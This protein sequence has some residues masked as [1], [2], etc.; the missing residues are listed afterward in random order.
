MNFKPKTWILL[1]LMLFIAAWFFW[2]QGEQRRSAQPPKAGTNTSLVTTRT[3]VAKAK[4][5]TQA[6]QPAVVFPNSLIVSQTASNIVHP[7]NA[8]DYKVSNTPETLDKLVVKDS[9][10]L[11]RN[12]WIDTAAA[13][14]LPIPAE[15]RATEDPGSYIVQSAG[16]ITPAFRQQLGEAGAAIISY[17][18]NNAYLVRLTASGARDLANSPLVQAVL[19]NE[20]LYKLEM[21]L[22]PEALGQRANPAGKVL[23]VTIFDDLRDAATAGIKNLGGVVVGHD[24]TPFG[25]QLL[26]QVPLGNENTVQKL[27]RMESVQGIELYR[28]RVVMNDLTRE[29]VKVSANTVTNVNY[30]G[31]TG[32]NVIVNVNDTGAYAGHPDLSNRVFGVIVTNALGQQLVNTYED[33][34]GHGTH[35]SGIIMSSGEN[36][37]SGNFLTNFNSVSNANFRGMAP[38]ASVF[39][40]PFNRDLSD[41]LNSYSSDAGLAEWA[42]RTNLL[43]FGR[44]NTL[45]SNNS[46][47]YGSQSY[48]SSAAIFDGAARDSLPDVPGSQPVLFIFAAGNSGSAGDLCSIT[49]FADTINSPATMK[50]GIA[51][52]A[53]ENLRNIGSNAVLTLGKSNLYYTCDNCNLFTNNDAFLGRTDS[54]NQVASFSSRGNTGISTTSIG[55]FKPDVVAPGTFIIS[56]R[57]PST[58]WNSSAYYNPTNAIDGY[59]FPQLLMK[60]GQTNSFPPVIV[61]DNTVRIA[62][63]ATPAVTSS[64]NVVI[65]ASTNAL[66]SSD[67]ASFV[68]TNSLIITNF[69]SSNCFGDLWFVDVVIPGTEQVVFDFSARVLATNKGSILTVLSNMNESLDPNELYRFESGTSMAAPAVSGLAALMQEFFEQRLG[70]TNSPALMKALLINGARSVSSDYHLQIDPLVNQQGWGLVNIQ[71]SIPALLNTLSNTTDEAAWPIRFYDQ[72]PTNALSTGQSHT[73]A[74]SVTNALAVRAPLRVTLVWTDPPGNPAATINLV[75]DLDLIV[76]NNDT[77]EVFFGNNFTGGRDFSD[78]N[79]L[80]SNSVPVYSSGI[81]NDV[82]NN[83]ENVYLSA[84]LGTNYSITVSARRVNVNAITANTND[85]VQDY[86]LVISSGDTSI[87]NAFSIAPAVLNINTNPAVTF[88][89]IGANDTTNTLTQHKSRGIVLEAQRVG[90]NPSMLV[91]TNGTNLQWRFYVVTNTTTF[92]NALFSIFS[93]PTLSVGQNIS[94]P[95]AVFQDLGPNSGL[96]LGR[97]ISADLDLF[98]STNYALTN[99][100]DTAIAQA[101][102]SVDRFSDEAVLRTNSTLGD[103]YYIGVKSED[104]QA[105]EFS[106]GIVF[107]EVNPY[108]LNGDGSVTVELPFASYDIPDGSPTEPRGAY[109]IGLPAFPGQNFDIGAVIVS[110]QFTHQL[111]GDLTGILTFG[112][113]QI[114]LNNHNDFIQGQSS[115]TV[116]NSYDDLDVLTTPPPNATKS[117]GPGSLADF[118]GKKANS[119]S[120]KFYMIDNA[121]SFTGRVDGVLVTLFPQNTNNLLHG[122]SGE[123]FG[124]TVQPGQTRYGA[125]VVPSTAVSLTLRVSIPNAAE[126]PIDLLVRRD[127]GSTPRLPSPSNFDY[128]KTILFP[129]DSLTIGRGDIPPLVAGTYIVAI[130]CPTTSPATTFDVFFDMALD[131]GATAASKLVSTNTVS[132]ED[133]VFTN[134]YTSTINVNLR[135]NQL[136]SDVRVGVRIDHPRVSDLVLHLVSPSG[137]SVLLSENRGHDSTNGFGI[138]T[139]E[140]EFAFTSFSE[141]TDKALVPIKFASNSNF[142]EFIPPVLVATN[143]F[144]DTTNN[145]S[146]LRA[147]GTDA[148][149]RNIVVTGTNSGTISVSYNF[150]SAPDRM[151]IYYG[152]ALIFDTTLISGTGSNTIAYGPGTDD[153]LEIVMNE[154]ANTNSTTVWDYS[155]TL[156]P[157]PPPTTNKTQRAT[158]VWI[159]GNDLY[160]S[161]MT[162]AAAT[163][164]IVARFGIPMQDNAHPIWE[165][166]WPDLKG[167]TRLNGVTA[168]PGAVFVAGDSYTMTVDDKA[169]LVKQPKGI[170]AS[171]PADAPISNAA[172]VYGSLWHKQAQGFTNVGGFEQLHGIT[173]V[174]ENNTNYIYVTGDAQASST[175]FGRMFVSKYDTNG[176]LLWTTNDFSP[177]VT[178]NYS[179]GRAITTLNGYVYVAGANADSGVTNAYLLK[180]APDGSLVW[181]NVSGNIAEFRGIAAYGNNIYTVGIADNAGVTNCLI[182]K[183][184]E[185]GASIWTNQLTINGIED[186]LNGV[187]GYGDRLYAVGSTIPTTVAPDNNRDVLL[188]E[189]RQDTG[190]LVTNA[191]YSG[192]T[193]Y[194]GGGFGDDIANAVATDGF[195]LYLV[196]EMHPFNR[197]D[198]DALLLRY[199]IKND[200]LPEE[201]LSL[202]TGEYA[203]SVI[204]G[205]NTNGWRLVIWDNRADTLVSTGKLVSWQLQLTLAATNNSADIL[206]HDVPFFATASSNHNSRY[207]IVN[208]PYTASLANIGITNLSGG[209]M[210]LYFNQ[211]GLPVDITDPATYLLL[212]GVPDG[213]AT[214]DTTTTFPPLLPGQRFYLRVDS[215]SDFVI[216]V[217]FDSSATTFMTGGSSSPGSLKAGVGGKDIYQFL[218]EP[219]SPPTAFQLWNLTGDVDVYLRRGSLPDSSH[220]DLHQTLTGTNFGQLVVQTNGFTPD[221]S[222]TWFASI[223]KLTTNSVAYTVVVTNANRS[224]VF[225][226]LNNQ[227]AVEGSLLS[228]AVPATDPDAPAQQVT[229]SLEPGAP[230]GASINTTTGVFSWTPTAS[231][232]PSSNVITIR[233]TDNGVPPISVTHNLSIVVNDKVPVFA[234]PSVVSGK[235]QITWSSLAGQNYEVQMST[236]LVNWTTIATNSASGSSTTYLDPEPNANKAEKFYRVRPVP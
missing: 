22:M 153:F 183:W 63:L 214:L 8:A 73:Y 17:I 126:G 223:G 167:R 118:L 76:T 94:D 155:Y 142:L 115:G 62:F 171:F 92:T 217:S 161:G 232:G 133:Q 88:I 85:V 116:A 31:L 174:L 218:I 61:P 98:V 221:V 182:Q 122:T 193:T 143:F 47:G 117:D 123:L 14:P 147:A 49:E 189:L 66:P 19:P 159:V 194:N 163:N 230:A 82:I 74:L 227:T 165:L 52:G 57:P 39:V 210:D 200:Y 180:Y 15:L 132:I 50:N 207:F 186:V 199:R 2:R 181:T 38:A 157:V 60:G 72:S 226:A 112:A 25:S 68:G 138:G 33:L 79:L 204:S 75:N 7:A 144:G 5:G 213:L 170:V 9:A 146:Q 201:P 20:P 198:N 177:S 219:S 169:D 149:D 127:D 108:Q 51:V 35:V 32:T 26:V 10:I 184:D 156:N 139:K 54:S 24:R 58:N 93:A 206:V 212:S 16:T 95:Y 104:Q 36:G 234:A 109:S 160:L 28:E 176:T 69:A 140:R 228:F 158:G 48:N 101:W 173:T 208:V 46:W 190:A 215:S 137:T 162:D 224:P 84:P 185:S 3:R 97:N 172:D 216:Q 141:D 178:T 87:S 202:F 43:V 13:N 148:E 44:T 12:A 191:V 18:P 120:L 154:G 220:Y 187:V 135:T 67:P 229:F 145:P 96:P 45:I 188:L 81:T 27:A 11:L 107:T 29:R 42:A 55:R 150:Y 41:N 111:F 197:P 211:G 121:V 90:A 89:D 77:G 6:P 103:V 30:L 59:D 23:R 1:S 205:T 196:G 99:L 152:G 130:H 136:V 91:S 119:S 164:G 100:D 65:Y 195:D 166:N 78:P 134:S 131:L 53:I 114:Y 64:N 128:S 21:A 192:V 236:N 168:I 231:Q 222:G 83:V 179:S 203:N 102:K 71:N 209:S 129:G 40:L 125:L 151:T 86:A 105:G 225:G 235:L 37:P 110:N 70:R 4:A 106:L 34:N 56:T 113:T 124:G 80:T 233:V 175:N